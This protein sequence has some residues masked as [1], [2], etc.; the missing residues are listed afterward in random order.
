V[1]G[2]G[3]RKQGSTRAMKLVEDK[4]DLESMRAGMGSEA[5]LL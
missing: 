3:K 1:A 5:G 4:E 2:R